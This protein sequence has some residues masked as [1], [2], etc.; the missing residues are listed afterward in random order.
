MFTFSSL[1]FILTICFPQLIQGEPTH[2]ISKL[3]S[4]TKIHIAGGRFDLKLSQDSSSTSIDI[5]ADDTARHL[6]LVDVIQSDILLIR[7][8]ENPNLVNQSKIIIT[9]TYS[10]LTELFIDGM[11]NIQCLNPIRVDQLLVHNRATG[12]VKLKVQINILDVYLHSIG[13]MKFCG[14]VNEEATIH[15]LGV[16]DIQCKGLFT[17]KVNVISSGI[18][19]IYV[20]ATDEVNIIL[21][22]IGTVFYTGPLRKQIRTGLGNIIQRID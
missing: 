13:R 12:F 20:Q 21:S 10:N 4:F 5:F 22:G 8:M 18:G 16:G 14:Q 6:V 3:N 11:I 19:N 17:K 15:S 1:S 9:I 7:M 2:Q